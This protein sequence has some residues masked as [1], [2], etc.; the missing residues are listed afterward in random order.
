[1]HSCYRAQVT[2]KQSNFLVF[3]SLEAS[4]L[5]LNDLNRF[6]DNDINNISSTEMCASDYLADD[7]CT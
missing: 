2:S 3:H 6:L 4:V 7:N 1:M 5:L